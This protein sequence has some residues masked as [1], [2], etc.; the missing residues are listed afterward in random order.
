MTHTHTTALHRTVLIA[1]SIMTIGT[2]GACAQAKPMM[3]ASTG[4]KPK[5]S[6]VT[7]AARI[8]AEPDTAKTVLLEPLQAMVAKMKKLQ[9]TGDADFDFGFQIKVYNEGIQ[10]LLTK[11]VQ[12]GKDDALKQMAQA[13][14]ET[15][16][17]EEGTI[18][19]ILRKVSPS[20]PNQAFMQQQNKNIDAISTQLQQVSTGDSLSSDIDKNFKILFADQRQAVLDLSTT[21]LQYGRSSSLKAY[22]QQVVDRAK[23]EMAKIKSMMN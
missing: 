10:N 8:T 7:G 5:M 19:D 16:K 3:S 15:A 18:N 13:M 12:S 9:P 17:A 21:Y 11:E 14:L 22:A 4:S 23:S 20:R 1:V 2:M 6:T